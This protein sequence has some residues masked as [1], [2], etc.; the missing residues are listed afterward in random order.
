MRAWGIEVSPNCLLCSGC[1]ESRQHLFFDCVYSSEIWA[2]FCSRTRVTPPIVFEDC[3]RW[4]RNSSTDPNILLVV[5]LIFQ[6]VVYM[7]WKERNA[8]LHSNVSRP[9]HAIIQEVK[10]TVRLR[11]DLL[12]RNMRITS[13]SSLTYLGSWLSLF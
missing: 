13:N 2:Y 1:D 11:L 4:L 8:R 6:A 3:L 9:T 7:V 12:S 10:Q 5:K